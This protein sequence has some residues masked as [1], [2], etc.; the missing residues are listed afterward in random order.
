MLPG[1]K[2]FRFPES[3]VH[4]LLIER[5]YA[6]PYMSAFRIFMREP[7]HNP[8]QEDYVAAPEKLILDSDRKVVIVPKD[9]VKGSIKARLHTAMIIGWKPI[10]RN[11]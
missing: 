4:R 5:E 2:K 1:P 9:L 10:A 11:S 8:V 3:S 7:V 6:V